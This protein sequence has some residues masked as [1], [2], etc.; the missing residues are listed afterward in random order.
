M[1][2]IHL[3]G[4]TLEAD[5][6]AMIIEVADEAGVYIPRFCY[7][8]KLSIAANCRM[9][10]VEVEGVGKPLP[11]CA[12]P[13]SDGMTVHT[14]SQKTLQAQRTVME[15][16]LTNHPL[17]CPVCD[18]GGQCE[19]QDLAMGYGA[20]RSQFD[21][22]KRSVSD[23]DIG[24]LI[25][26]EMTR[27]IHCTRCVRFGQEIAGYPE[28]GL[29]G[30]GGR[31]EVGTF[32]SKLMDSEVASNVIDL[33]P[34]GALNAKPSAKQGRPWHFTQHD[35]IAPHDALG[36]NIYYHTMA[37]IKGHHK[38]VQV[39]PRLNQDINEQ[40]IA[41]RD[42]FAYAGL[43][44][45]D[46]IHTPMM[47]KKDRWVEVS[48]EEALSQIMICLDAISHEGEQGGD[49]IGGLIA[50][51]ATQESLFLFQKLLRS[52]G[53]H[54]IDSRLKR[55]D[56][57]SQHQDPVVP[58]IGHSLEELIQSDTLWL[59]DLNLHR[60]VPVLGIHVR[61]ASSHQTKV[62]LTQ[63]RSFQHRFDN[64]KV[65]KVGYE[66]LASHLAEVLVACHKLKKSKASGQEASLLKGI[67]PSA[68]ATLI[69]ERLCQSE[70]G[71]IV[72][73][74]WVQARSDYGVVHSLLKRISEITN[75]TLGFITDGPNTASAYEMG[76]LPH[77]GPAG[78]KLDHEGMSLGQMIQSPRKAMLLAGFEPEHDSIFGD[79]LIKALQASEF[80]VMMS[81]YITESMKSYAD[82]ILPIALPSEE[83]GTYCNV[84]GQKQSF[85]ASASLTQETKP[86]W[87]V[88]RA[89]GGMMKLQD[90]EHRHLE[91]VRAE[92]HGEL[93]FEHDAEVHAAEVLNALPDA[94][95]TTML[96]PYWPLYAS[97]AIVR[98][99]EALQNI[100]EHNP[101]TVVVSAELVSNTE[102]H[103]KNIVLTQGEQSVSMPYAV[104]ATLQGK[105]VLAPFGVEA[106][107]VLAPGA[108]DIEFGGFVDE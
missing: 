107:S 106:S 13:V 95:T 59:V 19:L 9:C 26:T 8:K 49:N 37:D 43:H 45:E 16:L 77:R 62:L 25:Y 5:Q 87:K 91:D 44:H 7:H 28:L 79:Q 54:H 72:L 78:K 76:A 61:Q 103:A 60:E 30:R 94:L 35:S 4:K 38:I 31:T 56:F 66:N 93:C 99:S 65:N 34:V 101:S 47:K 104:D 97:D 108:V 96:Q 70:K 102:G 68:D 52:L 3:D 12:T 42:R 74:T 89:L 71:S 90:F 105:V 51:S 88:L 53:S 23:K 64:T 27:C 63:T 58:S 50:P 81:G 86:L 17:D 85:K 48:W 2:K 18:Q 67:K 6:N 55:Q 80:V 22:D 10:L 100:Q 36:A 39:V 15:F 92:I 40:W 84:L 11:A 82:I 83:A 21:E 73:G 1:V 98:R 32:V 75:I 20:D 46:R 41:D 14:Q 24:P 33:C 29:T 69:A 57:S